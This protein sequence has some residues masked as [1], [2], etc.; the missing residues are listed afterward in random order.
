M[1]VDLAQLYKANDKKR[2]YIRT[3]KNGTKYFADYTCKRC[4]GQGGLPQWTST[5]YT[6]YECG[7]T[8]V[9]AK[10]DIY[11]E[12]T[13]EYEAKLEERRAKAREKKRLERIEQVKNKLPEIY[14]NHGFSSDG[15]IFVVTGNTY[16]IREELKAAGAKWFSAL[17]SWGFTE[18]TDNSLKTEIV[19][20][21]NLREW[22]NIFKLRAVGVTGKPHPQMLEVMVPLLEEVKRQ[23]P[24]VFDDLVTE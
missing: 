2:V 22:R 19:V 23:I 12:Y 1:S 3:D 24:V 15:K 18:D 14:Q 9:A 7:G 17:R 4:G 20:T 13:P 5:G 6:C 8:G 16:E 21:A 11:K 10:P